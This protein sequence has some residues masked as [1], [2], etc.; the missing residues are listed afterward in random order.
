M[1]QDQ[2]EIWPTMHINKLTYLPRSENL[3]SL[4]MVI[5]GSYRM[6]HQ[7]NV[8]HKSLDLTVSDFIYVVYLAVILAIMLM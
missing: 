1:S 2:P 4:R 3:S 5:C 6:Q 7:R 8:Y